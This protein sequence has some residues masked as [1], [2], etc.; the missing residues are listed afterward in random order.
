MSVSSRRFCK[1][2]L[3][4][5]VILVSTVD[6]METARRLA[7]E[8]GIFCGTSS[9]ANVLGALQVAKKLGRGKNIVTVAVDT[10]LKYLSTEVFR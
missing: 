3:Y 8:E 9:G 6:A 4:D 7:R 10:G 1:E 5:E 2:S